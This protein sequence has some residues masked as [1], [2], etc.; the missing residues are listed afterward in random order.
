MGPSNRVRLARRHPGQRWPRRSPQA[1]RRRA[2]GSAGPSGRA[3]GSAPAAPRRSR[4]GLARD[5]AAGRARSA[6]CTARPRPPCR[7]PAAPTS[8]R[9]ASHPEERGA[10]D[11]AEARGERPPPSGLH[12]GATDASEPSSRSAGHAGARRGE[13]PGDR[14]R[15]VT[16]RPRAAGPLR[17]LARRIP[18]PPRAPR[19]PGAPSF[20]PG[21]PRS[22][23]YTAPWPRA[24]PHLPPRGGRAPSRGGSRRAR[25]T[26]GGRLLGPGRRAGVDP[27][28]RR[29]GTR[30]SGGRGQHHLARSWSRHRPGSP[31]H[32]CAASHQHRLDPGQAPRHVL[33]AL[34]EAKTALGHR[35]PQA[36]PS[37]APGRGCR[38]AHQRGA[39]TGPGRP[40]GRRR[41]AH[42]RGAASPAW[43]LRQVPHDP[44]PPARPL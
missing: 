26:A 5:S 40:P 27:R 24:G 21:R 6:S 36:R 13:R 7:S 19:C 12:A 42:S 10:A 2:G 37:P 28:H 35:C 9:T 23:R 31:A 38:S 11:V 30:P 32:R 39:G 25:E 41:S 16:P 20:P 17:R 43:G 33:H 14:E 1:C 15:W 29:D 4:R 18:A 22:R 8:T 34:P 3:P 44:V